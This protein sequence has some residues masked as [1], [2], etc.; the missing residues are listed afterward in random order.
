MFAR[1]LKSAAEG[2]IRPALSI[3]ALSNASSITVKSVRI[4]KGTYTVLPITLIVVLSL[5]DRSIA[6][7]TCA[8][9][10]DET[11][12]DPLDYTVRITFGQSAGSGFILSEDGYI[13][14]NSHVV[15]HTKYGNVHVMLSDGTKL[16]GKIHSNLTCCYHH[17]LSTSQRHK[18]P[19]N[20][21]CCN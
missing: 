15:S 8:G 5:M 4:H 18:E 19:S 17:R 13:V 3:H 9:K 11:C 14:T 16:P 2:F 10:K 21:R 7:S 20:T 12:N 1:F 6:V